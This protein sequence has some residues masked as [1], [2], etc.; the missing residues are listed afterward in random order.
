MTP[1]SSEPAHN[2]ATLNDEVTLALRAITEK[3]AATIGYLLDESRQRQIADD[4]AREAIRHYGRDLGY[5]IRAQMENERDLQEFAGLFTR[6]LESQVYEMEPVSIG[7]AEFIVLF[8]YCPYVNCWQQQGRGASEI[9][10]LCDIC[11]EGDH[12]LTDAFSG[13][14]LEVQTALARGDAA[15]RLRFYQAEEREGE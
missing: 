11:M 4:F 6:G 5:K 13:L 8:H 9:A 14:H 12:A 1:I 15:C 3:R 2:A 7:R 10:M